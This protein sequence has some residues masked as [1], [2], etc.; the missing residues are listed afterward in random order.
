M[1]LI[2]ALDRGLN[3][4]ELLAS[5]KREL[6]FNEILDKTGIP[7]PSLSRILRTLVAR[8][9]LKQSRLNKKYW[10]GSKLL[11]VGSIILD[12]LELREIARPY[13]K[14]LVEETGET[15]E[16]GILDEGKLLY[17]DKMESTESIRLFARIGSRYSNLHASATG[18]VFLA[19]FSNEELESFLKN[20]GLPKITEETITNPSSLRKELSEIRREGYA[21][22]DQ[23]VRLGVRR[24]ATPIFDHREKLAG[25]IGI[26]G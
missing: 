3:I 20:N 24:I 25:V 5:E 19:Y 22:D 6:G 7:K 8:G 11:V 15:A 26:A 2:P 23:E 1:K 18:K 16:L 13:L 12:H 9:Y 10:L 14:K 17:I 21:F 4:L